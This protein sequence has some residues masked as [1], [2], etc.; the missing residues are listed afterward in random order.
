MSYEYDYQLLDA[1]TSGYGLLSD[2][3]ALE[4]KVPSLDYEPDLDDYEYQQSRYLRLTPPER[5]HE[6][7]QPGHNR[8]PC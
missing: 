5:T 1:L 7:A 8:Y 4:E 3:A 2:L 6:P